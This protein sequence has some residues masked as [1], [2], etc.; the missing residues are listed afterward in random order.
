MLVNWCPAADLPACSPPSNTTETCLPRLSMAHTSALHPF[1]PLSLP[2]T[3]CC[4]CCDHQGCVGENGG[5]GREIERT[6]T[7]SAGRLQPVH[8]TPRVWGR[9]RADPSCIQVSLVV[10]P[11]GAAL[12][13]AGRRYAPRA[14][15]SSGELANGMSGDGDGGQGQGQGQGRGSG[16]AHPG[17]PCRLHAGPARAATPRGLRHA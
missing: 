17:R 4:S 12:G 2:C 13:P 16:I 11:Y 1:P 15:H 6:N 3:A 10:L 9:A 8:G 5:G 7:T 14:L